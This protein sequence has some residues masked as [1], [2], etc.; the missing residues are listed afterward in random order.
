M[1]GVPDGL[2]SGG[3]GGPGAEVELGGVPVAVVG[4]FGA[5]EPGFAGDEQ[6]AADGGERGEVQG[7]VGEE[8]FAGGVDGGERGGGEGG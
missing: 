1:R 4:G 6:E 8:G 2:W 3:G 7:V 5:E